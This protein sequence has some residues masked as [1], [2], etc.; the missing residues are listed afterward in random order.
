MTH[1]AATLKA[2]LAEITGS[3]GPDARASVTVTGHGPPYGEDLD[4]ALA[5]ARAYA[6]TIIAAATVAEREYASWVPPALTAAE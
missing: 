5:S 6:A 3:I 1:T 2:A 4:D